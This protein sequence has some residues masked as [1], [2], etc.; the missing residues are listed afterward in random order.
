MSIQFSS[1]AQLC[2]TLCD[3]INYSMAA[4][5]VH[6]QLP[7]FTQTHVHWVGDAINHLIFCCPVL[8]LPSIFPSIGVFS[9]ESVLCIRWPK[10]WSFSFSISPS[11]ECSGLIS[12][13]M[14]SFDLLAVQRTLKSLLQH[15]SSKASVLWRSAFFTV[16]LSPP[17][18]T[19]GK[20]I[21]LTRWT[22]VGKVMS[23]L[24]NK[25]TK[26]TDFWIFRGIFKISKYLQLMWTIN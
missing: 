16:Q 20:T 7:E 2:P 14:D 25:L 9:N 3:P 21:A 11:N 17:Y 24:F 13:R 8:L 22:F 23:L 15:H 19:S 26:P 5:P 12:F 18:M 6:Y 1:V 4:F 10:Y